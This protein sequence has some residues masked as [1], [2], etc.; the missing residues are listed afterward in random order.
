[1]LLVEDDPAVRNLA[2]DILSGQGYE[3]LEAP[4]G[5]AA[6]RILDDEAERILLMI[7]D[8][9]MPKMSGQELAEQVLANHPNV[10]VLFTT[11]YFGGAA[12]S[13]MHVPGVQ[14]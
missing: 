10:K 7:T 3:V 4:D 12:D 13:A 11:G 6:L 8:L 2:S 9:V 1:M 5:R 14:G